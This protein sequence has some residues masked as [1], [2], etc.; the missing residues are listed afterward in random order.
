MDFLTDLSRNRIPIL[1]AT[2]QTSEL[3]SLYPLPKNLQSKGLCRSTSPISKDRNVLS[4]E[5]AKLLLLAL[6]ESENL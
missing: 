1:T 5:G 3:L 4:N 2:V 6:M